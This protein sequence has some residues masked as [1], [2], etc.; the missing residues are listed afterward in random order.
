MSTLVSALIDRTLLKL[1]DPAGWRNKR[2]SL[3]Q[4]FNET[5]DEIATTLKALRSDYYFD[6][7]ANEGAYSYPANRIQITG[8]RVARVNPPSGLGDYYP[9]DEKFEDE[10]RSATAMNRPSG[11]VYGYFALPGWFELL[12]LPDA[13]APSGGIIS[14]YRIPEWVTVETPQ[15]VMELPD[16]CRGYVLEGMLIRARLAGRDRAA[17]EAEHAVWLERLNV[18]QE[19]ID[20]PSIDRRAAIRPRGADD[21]T[22]GMN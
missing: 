16:F 1:E 17:A 9:L 5:Q 8:I 10:F 20:D 22:R 7:E 19:K 4:F 13:D 18:L 12:D 2:P 15:A 3:L 11:F 14:T 21:W 6:L